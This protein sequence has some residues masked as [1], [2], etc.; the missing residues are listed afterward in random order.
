MH[1][2]LLRAAGADGIGRGWLWQTRNSHEKPQ[3]AKL[4]LVGEL[5]AGAAAP[6]TISSAGDASALPKHLLSPQGSQGWTWGMSQLVKLRG[7]G[8]NQRGDDRCAAVWVNSAVDVSL[9]Y[10]QLPLLWA[11]E[12][13]T[14]K[15]EVGAGPGRT[16]RK[17]AELPLPFCDIPAVLPRAPLSW[18]LT[19]SLSLQGLEKTK[20]E[21]EKLPWLF[22]FLSR[23]LNNTDDK[24]RSSR[25]FSAP[26]ESQ[27]IQTP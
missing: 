12:T 10:T 19:S 26:L 18:T 24:Q 4:P 9:H 16:L 2:L 17:G 3:R 14:I 15:T 8:R 13:Q 20:I 7:A 6:S 27:D 25:C 21:A 1:L 23:R 22:F 5:S 11:K